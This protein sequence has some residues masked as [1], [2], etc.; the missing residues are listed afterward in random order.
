M[1]KP[2]FLKTQPLVKGQLTMLPMEKIKIEGYP[3]CLCH[4]EDKHFRM[5]VLHQTTDQCNSRKKSPK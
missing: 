1:H 2:R 3:V 4:M 5:T